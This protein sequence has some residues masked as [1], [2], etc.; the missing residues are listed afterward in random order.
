MCLWAL[1]LCLFRGLGRDKAG[2]GLMGRRDFW[3]F[4]HVPSCLIFY[5]VCGYYSNLPFLSNIYFL[6][7]EKLERKNKKE[8]ALALALI[9]IQLLKKVVFDDLSIYSI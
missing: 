7:K 9:S 3:S 4:S 5:F 1:V 8:N 6:G 2:R